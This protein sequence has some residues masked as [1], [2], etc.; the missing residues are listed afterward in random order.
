MTRHA[1]IKLLVPVCLSAVLLAGCGG[2]EGLGPDGEPLPP[3]EELPGDVAL[4]SRGALGTRVSD[5]EAQFPAVHFD[6]DSFLIRDD[7]ISTI[8]RVAAYMKRNRN[9][10]LVVEG[11]CDERG[12]REY[13]I[14]LGE[15]R[16]LAVRAY[17]VRLGVRSDRI[18]TRSYGEENPAD[19]A[20][21]QNAWRKNR[22]AEFVFYR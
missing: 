21:D 5:P 19:P 7:G 2:K 14:S 4:G 3:F 11:H 12:S 15:H 10:K 13:N 8:E 17:L 9:A 16:G 1:P 22:R 20:H 18:Q 6:Y